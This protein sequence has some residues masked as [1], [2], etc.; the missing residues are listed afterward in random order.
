MKTPSNVRILLSESQIQQRV[1]ELG[2]TLTREYAGKDL[3]LVGCLK[4]S[5]I[6]LSDLA[7]NIDLPLVREH[8]L[9]MSRSWTAMHQ[10][11][12]ASPFHAQTTASLDATEVELHVL[13]IGMDD[14]TMQTVHASHVYYPSQILWQRRHA[15]VLSET[16]DGALLLDLRRFHDTEASS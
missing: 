9:S 16:R 6:F 2:E 12:A 3:C 10:V 4:G 15:D 7:R 13:L 11:D 5:A 14:T 8:A 1:R